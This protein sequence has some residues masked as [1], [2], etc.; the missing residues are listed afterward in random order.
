V[1]LRGHGRGMTTSALSSLTAALDDL[2]PADAQS[3][4]G[5]LSLGLGALAVVAPSRTA[6]LFGVRQRSG[7][8]PLLVRMIGVRNAVAGLRTLQA[9]EGDRTRALQAGLA[10]GVVDATAVLLAARKGVLSKRA[11]AGILVVLAGI[12]ALGAVA[13]RELD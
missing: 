12:A 1:R 11:A 4:V 2:D 9:D 7:P 13:S 8:V 5:G 6:A 10:L 3:V